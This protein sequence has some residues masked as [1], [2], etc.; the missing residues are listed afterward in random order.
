MP[1]QPSPRVLVTS[2]PTRAYIDRV[3]YIANTS[4]GSLGAEIVSELVRRGMPAVHLYG[5]GS[6]HLDPGS[7][8]LVRSIEVMTVDDLISS[9]RTVVAG[10]RITAVI[11]AMAV[12]DYVPAAVHEGKKA[13]GDDFWTLTLKKTPKVI[14]MMRELLPDACFV[15]FKL[16][17]G[18][19]EN[20]LVRKAG[21]LLQK[22]A[23]D[24]VVANDLDKVSQDR[25][26]A[27]LV[28]GGGTIIARPENKREIAVKIVEFIRGECR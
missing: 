24:L 13:S 4:S 5:T 1:D 21:L 28:T 15:G 18:V 11:H 26:D 3:R 9:V 16:E 17:A 14:G 25:H 6:A 7:T 23:L 12:L 10:E 20:E 22:N 8:P 19:D 27:L 2:G